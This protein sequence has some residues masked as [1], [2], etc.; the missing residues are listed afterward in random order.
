M[1]KSKG[2]KDSAH[3]CLCVCMCASFTYSRTHSRTHSLT[4]MYT[5]ISSY[6]IANCPSCTALTCP[7]WR[8]SG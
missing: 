7:Q 6:L 8:H 2:H 3:M 4:Q 1:I 5:R